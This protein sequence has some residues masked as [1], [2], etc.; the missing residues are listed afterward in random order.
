[1]QRDYITVADRRQRD[2]AEIDQIAGNGEIDVGELLSVSVAHDVVV[3]SYLGVQGG[4]KRHSRRG[5]KDHG[6]GYA[7]TLIT[8]S[9]S[10]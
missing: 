9:T 5:D 4:G 6:F 10:A 1:M 2:E 3:R 8:A 7:T